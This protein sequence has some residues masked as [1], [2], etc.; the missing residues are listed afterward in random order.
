MLGSE[1]TLADGLKLVLYAT[2]RD[3]YGDLTQLI[4]RG[5]RN[6]KKGTYRLTRED[7]TEVAPR[8]LALWVP[9]L[10]TPQKAPSPRARGEGWGE[11]QPPA[12]PQPPAQLHQD[13]HWFAD[14]FPNRTCPHR[15]TATAPSG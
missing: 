2:D 7:V 4:T 11:G 9:A 5:R 10:R 8:C 1:F 13:A 12:D 3:T 15:P 14:N 6:A